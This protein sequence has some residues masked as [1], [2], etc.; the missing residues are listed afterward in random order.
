M[1]V[2]FENGL[3]IIRRPD[4]HCRLASRRERSAGDRA[5]WLHHSL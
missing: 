1:V 2:L 4:G 5:F 3:T